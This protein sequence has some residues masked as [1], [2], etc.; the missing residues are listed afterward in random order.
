[1]LAKF[2]LINLLTDTLKDLRIIAVGTNFFGALAT[3][4]MFLM[5]IVI[6]L[7]H[8]LNELATSLFIEAMCY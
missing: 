8:Q 6:S 1:M 3:V 7:F 2:W 4:I 5:I